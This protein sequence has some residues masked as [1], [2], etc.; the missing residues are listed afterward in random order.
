MHEQLLKARRRA[1]RIEHAARRIR[2]L[3]QKGR[4]READDA[5]AAFTLELDGADAV[6]HGLFR[7]WCA[8]CDAVERLAGTG[9]R[10]R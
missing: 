1:Q 9:R 4:H 2:R 7:Q 5:L 10:T 6:P 3:H 8:L